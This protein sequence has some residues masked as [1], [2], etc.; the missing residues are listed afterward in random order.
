MHI[1]RLNCLQVSW[2]FVLC[3]TITVEATLST[4]LQHERKIPLKSNLKCKTSVRCVQAPLKKKASSLPCG[5]FVFSVFTVKFALPEDE[6]WRCVLTWAK[7]QAGVTASPKNWQ[8]LERKRV[9][10]VS[11]M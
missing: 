8:E 10:E 4:T 6:V 7:H 11:P 5:L 2:L 9:A 1:S 3:L